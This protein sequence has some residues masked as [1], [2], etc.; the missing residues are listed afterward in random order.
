MG[1]VAVACPVVHLRYGRRIR[2]LPPFA[3][4]ARILHWVRVGVGAERDRGAR[5][6][7]LR[8][9]SCSICVM[10]NVQNEEC[11][12]AGSVGRSHVGDACPA[13]PGCDNRADRCWKT[14]S[15]SGGGFRIN[16][17]TSEPEAQSKIADDFDAFLL[18]QSRG[19]RGW[20]TATDDDVFDWACFLDSQGHEATW[21]HDRSCPGVSLADGGA[22]LPGSGWA[23]RYAA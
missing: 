20:A 14:G 16:G 3:L 1:C 19:L 21:V 18:T 2:P 6:G 17:R 8:A 13:G 9:R 5:W 4:F 15:S 22:Y 10:C 23:K 12:T 7:Y 11:R